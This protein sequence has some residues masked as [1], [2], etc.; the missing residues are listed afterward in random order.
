MALVTIKKVDSNLTINSRV[1]EKTEELIRRKCQKGWGDLTQEQRALVTPRVIKGC[2]MCPLAY[3][4]S[5]PV[6]P[7]MVRHPKLLAIGRNPGKGDDQNSEIM[8]TEASGGRVFARY[9]RTL[10]LPS[11]EVHVTNVCMCRTPKNGPPTPTQLSICSG[12]KSLELTSID[13]PHYILAMGNDA[14]R[15]LM[16]SSF[17]SVGAIYG[18]MYLSTV[19]SQDVLIV[20]IQHPGFILRHPEEAKDADAILTV[21][22]DIMHRPQYYN[23]PWEASL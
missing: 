10:G 6:P 22:N 17:P 21:L 15:L 5:G 23:L 8:S 11:S 3:E 20:P 1:M 7:K 2:H 9:L 18:D 12:W 4:Y 16:G 13:I 14:L 19:L